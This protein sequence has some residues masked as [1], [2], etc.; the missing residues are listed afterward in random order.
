MIDAFYKNRFAIPIVDGNVV[1]W[2]TKANP[3]HLGLDFS[4]WVKSG[5]DIIAAQ[6]GKVVDVF[7]SASCGNSIVL[8]HDYSDGTHAWT[9]YIHLAKLPTLR[10]GDTVKMN[11]TIGIKGN[12]GTSNGEHLHLYL[13]APTTAK[14]TWET[15]KANC[16]DPYPYLYRSKDFKY[17]YL[18][19]H[20]VEK[21]YLE[22]LP[23]P[24][25]YPTPVERNEYVKQVNVLIDYLYLRNAPS[26]AAYEKYATKGVYNILKEEIKNNYC[27]YLIDV[28]DGKE[29]WCAS[30]GTRTEDLLP[31]LSQEEI[32][33]NK[34]EELEKAIEDAAIDIESM[35]AANEKLL[36]KV[37]SLE[38]EVLN[39]R[40]LRKGTEDQLNTALKALDTLKTKIANAMKA[41][42]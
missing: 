16:V 38:G 24:I 36:E 5:A 25:K 40:N 13:T 37:S 4:W 18:G 2:F 28:V 12:T 9:G 6:D 22:D 34:V 41:L 42:G 26:G 29:F 19:S 32:L 14:Y 27:W 20:L 15:M 1:K 30:G 11:Q 10:I 23:K 21:P 17:L 3:I 8:Q 33:K 35:T 7:Y 39:E 31:K